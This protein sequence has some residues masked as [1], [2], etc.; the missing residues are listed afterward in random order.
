MTKSYDLG[1]FLLFLSILFYFSKT[2][3]IFKKK[4]Y[5]WIRYILYFSIADAIYSRFALH[6]DL[7]II[8]RVF[9]T[10]AFFAGFL[11]FYFMPIRHARQVIAILIVITFIQSILYSAQNVV[12]YEILNQGLDASA[13]MDNAGGS[14][15]VRFYNL[16]VFLVPAFVITLVK[17]DLF[18][19]KFR[20]LLLVTFFAVVLLSLHRT[21]LFSLT[22]VTILFLLRQIRPALWLPYFIPIFAII[23]IAYNFMQERIDQGLENLT[24]LE[25]LSLAPGFVHS[26]YSIAENA[27]NTSMYRALH[28]LERFDYVRTS[29]GKIMFGIGFLTEDAPQARNLNFEVGIWDSDSSSVIQIDTGDI[30]WSRLILQLGLIGSLLYLGVIV[31]YIVYFY[32]RRFSSY[33]L[34]GMYFL[35]SELIIS[36]YSV[37]LASPYFRFLIASFIAME[38]FEKKSRIEAQKTIND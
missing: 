22:L 35:V 1:L 26:N 20:I 10:Y 24:S 2:A 33:G 6:Y 17:R 27:N 34:I 5:T 18:S 14:G 15:F 13:A 29:A 21:Y 23:L 32:K 4:E 31:H 19:S 28:F 16:P 30:T 37:E 36:F 11:L 38:L 12:G 25:S 8:I 7:N 3:E 9:R